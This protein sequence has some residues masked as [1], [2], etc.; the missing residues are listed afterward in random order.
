MKRIGVVPRPGHKLSD[1][2]EECLAY[3]RQAGIP[4][5]LGKA[6]NG[7]GILRV[8]VDIHPERIAALL[9]VRGFGVTEFAPLQP[10][11]RPRSSC[12]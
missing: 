6:H 8:Y 4:A 3:L 9:R 7:Y 5:R 1:E 12:G 2:A 11:S 10:S